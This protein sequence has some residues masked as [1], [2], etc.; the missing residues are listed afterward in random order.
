MEGEF[1]ILD[2][3]T[4]TQGVAYDYQS[5][6]HPGAYAFSKGESRTID[7]LHFIDYESDGTYP[8]AL[9]LIHIHITYCEGNTYNEIKT[10]HMHL[11]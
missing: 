6:M 8:S 5:I 7:R 9:D 1:S 4:S 10:Q 11:Q 3:N 2:K